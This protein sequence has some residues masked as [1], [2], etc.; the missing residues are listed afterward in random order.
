MPPAH[1]LLLHGQGNKKGHLL[2]DYVA[3]ETGGSHTNHGEWKP[4]EPYVSAD[5]RWRKRELR[6]PESITQHGN[7]V[8]I[9]RRVIRFGE[10]A[11]RGR[12]QTE[13]GEIIPAH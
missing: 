9:F 3:F 5:N 2:A 12:L 13:H 11:S 8:R 1:N 10:Q 6:L 4:I 7:R